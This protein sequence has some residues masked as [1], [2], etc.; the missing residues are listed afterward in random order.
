MSLNFIPMVMLLL[1]AAL[2][3]GVANIV[4]RQKLG[5]EHFL[6]A[7]R[8]LPLPFVVAVV[9]GDL[10][11]GGSTIGVCQRAYS[12]GIVASMLSFS[13]GLGFLVFAATMSARFRRL[14]AV[15]VP[16]IVGTLFDARTRLTSALVIGVAYFIIGI[17][18]IMAGGALLSPLLEIDIWLAELITAFI[19][20]VIITAGGLHSIALVNIVQLTVVLFGMLVS[21]LF[22]LALIGGT[23]LDGLNRIWSELPPSFWSFGTRHPLTTGGEVLGTVFTLFAAQAAITGIL[24]AKDQ[25]TAVKGAWIAGFVVMS[26][27]VPFSMLGMCARIHFGTS[28]PHG[29]SA[30]P[31]MML[32][33]NPFVAGIA[34]CGLFAAFISTGPLCFLASIQIVIRDFYSVYFNSNASDRRLVV[35]NRTLAVIVLFGGWALAVTFQEILQLTFWAFAFRA[36]IGVILLSVVYLGSRYVSESGAFWGLISGA[37]VFTA[38]TMA[39]S[40]Y[41]VHVA[42]P[43]M[44]TTFIATLVISRFKRRAHEL[45]P[46][47]QLA[48]HPTQS[49]YTF[50]RIRRMP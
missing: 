4:L 43:S 23:V 47:I 13:L 28:L 11:G 7:A 16:E 32:A 34:L 19:F 48:L 6:V 12:E 3:I 41:G 38:W 2:T 37:L 15:T 40:P 33:L 46:E 17:T 14:R 35:L 42:I 22:S 31:A 44:T 25:K 5:S 18:Q 39:G 30:A 36:G 10:L 45:S 24:A 20:V 1:Y 9:G 8:A 26:F 21:L 29:L 27:G 49:R 50:G